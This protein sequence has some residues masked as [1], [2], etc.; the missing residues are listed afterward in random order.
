MKNN[1]AT[2]DCISYTYLTHSKEK[3]TL[4]E[5]ANRAATHRFRPVPW[6]R[7]GMVERLYVNIAKGFAEV[8]VHQ[9]P[10]PR[11]PQN[12]NWRIEV[13][14]IDGRHAEETR[15]RIRLACE[16]TARD[17]LG[18]WLAEEAPL[19]T[20]AT[21][22]WPELVRLATETRYATLSPYLQRRRL[23]KTPRKPS[24]RVQ[25]SSH[26]CAPYP[27]ERSARLDLD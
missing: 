27:A 25:S 19:L 6:P 26:R 4:T 12:P 2:D 20:I 8:Y 22:T 1:L 18:L 10:W 11:Q 17:Y 21:V 5:V 16:E 23:R 24:R 15:T 3:R 9:K 7:G 14:G 13:T